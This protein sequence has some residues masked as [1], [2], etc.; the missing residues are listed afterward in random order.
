MIDLR[1]R[2]IGRPK[3]SGGLVFWISLFGKQKGAPVL[4]APARER[5]SDSRVRAMRSSRLRHDEGDPVKKFYQAAPTSATSNPNVMFSMVETPLSNRPC[6]R[7]PR[8]L[9]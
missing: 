4:S 7:R 5:P 6:P 8:P 1:F 9:H 3:I 2:A